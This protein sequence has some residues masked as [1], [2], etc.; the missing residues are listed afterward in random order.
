MQPAMPTSVTTSMK[1]A[2]MV[3]GLLAAI[4]ALLLW[5]WPP[6]TPTRATAAAAPPT[7]PATSA[8]ERGSLAETRELRKLANTEERRELATR[9]ANAQAARAA[10]RAP[11]AVEAPPQLPALGVPSHAQTEPI[12]IAIREMIP[13]LAECYEAARPTLGDD[14][15]TVKA[16]LTLTGDA[17]IGTLVDAERLIDGAGNPLPPAFD[18]CVRSTLQLIVLPPLPIGDTAMVSYPFKF[19]AR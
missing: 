7:A 19:S 17:D 4:G 16:E 3:V 1:R 13:H 14:E 12:R 18:D 2:G 6:G 10:T 5:Q 15:I 8:A 9:I 11:E